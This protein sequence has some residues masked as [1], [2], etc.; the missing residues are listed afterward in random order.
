M[1]DDTFEEL[2]RKSKFKIYND[3]LVFLDKI[4]EQSD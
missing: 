1:D 4:R 3:Y 2:R